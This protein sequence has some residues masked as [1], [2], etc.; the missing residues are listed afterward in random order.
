MRVIELDGGQHRE[1]QD[2]DDACTRYLQ[3]KG[4]RVLRFWNNDVLTNIASVLAVRMT[5]RASSGSRPGSPPGGE[6]LEP[7]AR[8]E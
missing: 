5:A 1:Q 2:Y 3:A 6:G 8:L 7:H 4:Y